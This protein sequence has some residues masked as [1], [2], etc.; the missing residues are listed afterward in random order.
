MKQKSIL[1]KKEKDSLS[2]MC[3]PVLYDYLCLKNKKQ[4]GV[5][6]HIVD[7]IECIDGIKNDNKIYY[8][9][10][11]FILFSTVIEFEHIKKTVLEKKVSFAKLKDPKFWTK[12]N[13]TVD[14]A[15]FFI[16]SYYNELYENKIKEDF[17]K[18]SKLETAEEYI[19]FR[20]E[21][22]TR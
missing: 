13:I 2:L 10:V 22:L 21:M 9:D 12:D 17:L 6:S 7:A 16:S 20:N 8:R 5:H 14:V 15:I 18:L 3:L 19:A 11:F 4:N 1:S